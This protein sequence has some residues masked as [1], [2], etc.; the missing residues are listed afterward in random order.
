MGM[1]KLRYV[2]VMAITAGCHVSGLCQLNAKA[3]MALISRIVPGHASVFVVEDLPAKEG[4]DV[5]EIES[6][7]DKIV[8]RG[9]NGVAIASALYF[10]LTHFCHCQITWNGIEFEYSESTPT[11]FQKNTPDFTLPIPL[12]PELL[13][14]QLQYE[15][16]GLEALGEGN[17]LDGFAW[18]QYAA[19][20][21]R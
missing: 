20:H 21:Y 8:L 2:I 9:K 13:H 7:N 14:L 4:T 17:R 11:G 16:V 19:G 6:R 18:H 1:I 15:L 3:S 10:Y 5:F 12:L